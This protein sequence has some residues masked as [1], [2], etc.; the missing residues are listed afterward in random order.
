MRAVP[1]SLALVLVTPAAHAQLVLRHSEL[2][3]GAYT[4]IGNLL[5]DC[6][7]AGSGTCVNNNVTMIPVDVDGV[8]ATT[9]SSAATLALPTGATVRRATLYVTAEASTT[10]GAYT[11]MPWIPTT[12][13][14]YPVL[15]GVGG[16]A[17]TRLDA[18]GFEPVNGGLGYL[19]RY[20]ATG[21]V[22]AS[23][24]YLV[25]D[26]VFPPA[27]YPFNR[28]QSW[29]LFVTYDDGSAPFLVNLYDGQFNCFM[30]TTTLS[31]TGFR[32]PSGVP[33]RAL[34]SAW[35]VDGTDQTAGE[36]L[37]VGALR[38]SNAQNPVNNIGNGS[39]SSPL[40]A[41]PRRPATFRVTEEMDLDTFDVSSAFGRSQSSV[42]AA[43]T[44]GAVD[45]ILYHL[46]AL[47][48]DVVAPQLVLEKAVSDLNGGDVIA[49]DELSYTLTAQNLGGDDAIEVVLRDPLPS[50]L[51][52]VPG[53]IVYGAPGVARTDAVADDEADA[54]GDE[55]VLRIGT[56]ATST[57]GGR[58]AVGDVALVSFRALVETTTAART[59]VNQ[60][61]LSAVG[62]QRGTGTTMIEVRSATVAVEARPPPPPPDAGVVL[63]SG[64]LDAAA[65][66]DAE[67]LA[68][69]T[70][71]PD[72]DVAPDAEALPDAEAP[73]AA[74][75]PDAV[76]APDAAVT[77]D[78]GVITPRP[79]AA[80]VATDAGTTT[81]DEGCSCSTSANTT[82]SGA[83]IA[84]GLLGL[85]YVRRR[86]PR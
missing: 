77:T 78:A 44:C 48:V 72:A 31:L 13:A 39:V 45:G 75:A 53:S 21:L 19:A 47:G 49:G 81:E 68:D 34:L 16:G 80:V 9:M 43:F 46:V 79:D 52:Y 83:W 42:A 33:A 36:S 41:I 6:P 27:A 74:P 8:P 10:V 29:V 2:V 37:T 11:G 57:R 56:A 65:L 70:P 73:D 35:S 20:D 23:G 67:A 85:V 86:R 55:L 58:L 7:G 76:V 51:A 60:A 4:A 3:N 18:E 62:A 59:L 30:N 38:V 22:T 84:L 71:A 1:L 40:G 14:A 32:T 82:T 50:G 24:E 54:L 12:T 69:A 63:D 26:A 15:V 25:A 66:P 28:V 61:S 64:A 5:I 17:Y